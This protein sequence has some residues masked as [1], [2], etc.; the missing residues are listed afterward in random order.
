LSS[1]ECTPVSLEKALNKLDGTSQLIKRK[2]LAACL[3][4][5][6]FDKTVKVEEAELFRA[7]ADVLGCPVPPWLSHE[8]K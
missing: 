1:D 4:C 8:E 3:D 7:I 6:T 2:L 5:L